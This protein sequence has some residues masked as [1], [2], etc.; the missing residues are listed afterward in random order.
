ML[1]LLPPKR[2]LKKYLYAL[3]CLAI[4]KAIWLPFFVLDSTDLLGEP[5]KQDI[6]ARRRYLIERTTAPVFGPA[7]MFSALPSQFRGEWAIGTISMTV[8]AL[9]NIAVRF[10]ETRQEA[11]QVV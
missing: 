3:I 10:P 6:M 9:T 1:K 4:I 2:R 11:L 5:G 7:S 8:A